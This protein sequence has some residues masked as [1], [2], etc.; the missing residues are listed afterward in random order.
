MPKAQSR[1]RVIAN[2]TSV[3]TR[4][5]ESLI[6]SNTWQLQSRYFRKIGFEL[7]DRATARPSPLI[8]Q[9]DY[10]LQAIETICGELTRPCTAVARQ[11]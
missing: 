10:C 2:E 5:S 3:I 1:E 4:L 6:L 9:T 7:T 11:E 8:P